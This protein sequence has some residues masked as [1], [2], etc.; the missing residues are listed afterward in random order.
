VTQRSSPPIPAAPGRL[1]VLVV[2]DGP[3]L[4]RAM[5]DDL[6]DGLTRAGCEVIGVLPAGLEILD[7]VALQRPDLIIIES[8]S[9]WRDALEHVCHATRAAPRPIVLFTDNRDTSEAGRA[10]AAGV[11]GYV[12]A[13]LSPERVRPV[14]EVAMARFAIEQSLRDE[15]DQTRGKLADRRLVERA[16]GLLMERLGLSEDDAFARLRRLAMDRKESL[17]TAAGRV[18]DAARLLG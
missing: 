7:A 3:T 17:A 11:S 10:I 6:H 18:I 1:R 2:C 13:G 15:L 5:R 8:A 4:D 14:L 12:V 9:D 16:K